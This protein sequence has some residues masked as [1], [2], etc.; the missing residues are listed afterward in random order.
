VSGIGRSHSTELIVV[1][2]AYQNN[3]HQAPFLQRVDYTT[4]SATE[5][6]PRDLGKSVS[7]TAQQRA[8]GDGSHSLAFFSATA[9]LAPALSASTS[10]SSAI[11]SSSPS[12]WRSPSSL[13]ERP[14]DSPAG[15]SSD[16]ADQH[17]QHTEFDDDMLAA[18]M[19]SLE[20][21]VENTRLDSAPSEFWALEQLLH[22]MRSIIDASL[23]G[24]RGDSARMGESLSQPNSSSSGIPSSSSGLDSD[25]QPPISGVMADI[26][27]SY[28]PTVPSNTSP[29]P[30]PPP[31]PYLN[32]A[33]SS[34]TSSPSSSSSPSE[35]PTDPAASSSSS[36]RPTAIPEGGIDIP[37]PILLLWLVRNVSSAFFTELISRSFLLPNSDNGWSIQL[38]LETAVR[39]GVDDVHEFL[40]RVF[41]GAT[42][43]WEF[44]Y[45]VSAPT[46]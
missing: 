12:S 29:P 19:A 44:G 43:L 45:F 34:S 2:P 13:S 35:H 31:P 7:Q 20:D 36:N 18:I 3:A 32:T 33:S 27:V 6:A 41:K 38:L 9:P 14:A 28:S 16:L 10:S 5:S 25:A 4:H 15:P 37:L 24:T 42:E 11:N 8:N 17:F 1:S 23:A 26:D 30:P 39:H 22:E 21:A 40:E 46:E